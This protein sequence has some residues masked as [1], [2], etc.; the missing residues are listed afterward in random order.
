MTKNEMKRLTDEYIASHE[1]DILADISSL[2]SVPSVRSAA[3]AG[4]PFG[5]ACAEAAEKACEMLGGM[6][7][8][9]VNHENYAID[10]DLTGADAESGTPYLGILAHLDVVAPGDGW[11][12]TDP[13]TVLREGDMIWG[14]GVSDDKGPAVAAMWALRAVKERLGAPLR[15]AR[16]ILGCSEETGGEDLEYYF[17]KRPVPET[18]F[19]PD[20]DYPLI[21][22]E[23]GRYA[24]VFSREYS[25]EE[26]LAL[27]RTILSFR[28]GVAA[29]AVPG[30]AECVL[31][32]VTAGECREKAELLTELYGVGFS[33]SGGEDGGTLNITASGRSAHASLPETGANALTALL[34][35]VSMLPLDPSGLSRALGGLSG[36][37]PSG[38][39]LGEGAGIVC[40]DESGP[41]TASLDILRVGGGKVEGVCDLRIPARADTRA[42]KAKL[43]G[44]LKLA[45]FSLS[46]AQPTPPHLVPA[47]SPIVSTLLKIYSEY[48]GKTAEPGSTG[49]GTYV[50]DIENGVAFGCQMPG[51][52]TNMHGPDEFQ[53][54]STLVLSAKMFAAA[55][56]E[57]CF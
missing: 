45:G 29:N 48:T 41:L 21:N 19:T 55:I 52:E 13:Y 44:R 9:P 30:K 14:R 57:M 53:R 5:P 40:S 31:K 36:V 4:E 42:V 6:G 16:L 35:L 32:G 23:K 47:D 39:C 7:F 17:K 38:A 15:T 1:E 43:D 18:V 33:F 37:F 2:V 12:K 51:E 25:E 27:D 28:A 3:A 11:T 22:C 24:P 26:N 50:H 34:A 10:C 8:S 54:I 46:D 56:I 49:G 20:A